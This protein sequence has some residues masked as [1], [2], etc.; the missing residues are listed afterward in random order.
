MEKTYI[1]AINPGSTSTKIAVYNG[2][3]PKFIQTLRHSTEEL[4]KYAMVTDQFSF[5]KKII[6]EQLDNEEIDINAIK[7]VMGRGG[8]LKP[9]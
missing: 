5:R 1:L 4:E 9:V 3:S 6:I 8:L 7:I 2:S